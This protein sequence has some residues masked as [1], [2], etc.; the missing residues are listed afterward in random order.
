MNKKEI[1]VMN[2]YTVSIDSLE[3]LRNNQWVNDEILNAFANIIF[4][5]KKITYLD[6]EF[7]YIIEKNSRDE[8]SS[9]VADRIRN[10]KETVCF[11]LNINYSHWICIR[12][13]I[14]SKIAYYYDPLHQDYNNKIKSLI[15]KILHPH[16][17][18]W[19]I[20]QVVFVKQ[21]DGFNCGIYCAYY[22]YSLIYKRF[23]LFDP[24][25]F[26]K[27]VENEILKFE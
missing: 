7:I 2:K 13:D 8:F 11:Y 4:H 3:K 27:F 14:K 25:K 9:K 22:F 1:K 5:N 16:H 19:S 10:L 26:R 12:L 20:E 6:T 17:V 15:K 24:S 18:T 21:R 23:R